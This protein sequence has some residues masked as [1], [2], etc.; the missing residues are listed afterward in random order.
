LF[1]L[2]SFGVFI[3]LCFELSVPVQ[4]IVW[5][6]SSPKW[7]IICRA[8]SKTLLTHSLRSLFDTATNLK[9]WFI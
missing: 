9:Y 1:I 7:H 3:P 8:G 2:C 6:D 4:V 5:K